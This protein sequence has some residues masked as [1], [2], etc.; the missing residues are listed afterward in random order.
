MA[1]LASV[2]SKIL[3]S[4]SFLC[5]SS[6]VRLPPSTFAPYSYLELADWELADAV[7]SASQDLEWERTEAQSGNIRI[8]VDKAGRL[9]ATGAGLQKKRTVVQD[10]DEEDDR[11]EKVVVRAKPVK[12][13]P[14]RELPSI[15][16]K[17][18]KAQDAYEAAPQHDNFGVELQ[19]FKEQGLT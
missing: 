12:V 17:S 13:T 10:D 1:T 4:T 19:S 3:S 5:L 11:A 16:T 7:Q 8:T 14:E 6:L 18:L 9:V 2:L 15:A